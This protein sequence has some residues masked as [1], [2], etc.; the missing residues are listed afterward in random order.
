VQPARR[1]HWPRFTGPVSPAPTATTGHGA[2]DRNHIVSCPPRLAAGR[3]RQSRPTLRRSGRIAFGTTSKPAIS[4]RNRPPPPARTP[5]RT[6]ALRGICRLRGQPWQK[7]H[8]SEMSTGNIYDNEE[9]KGL[10]NMGRT[11]KPFVTQNGGMPL[12]LSFVN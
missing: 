2:P 9:H 7:D 12:R 4:A 1:F 10:T 6:P 8:N 3:Q 11:V 5:A